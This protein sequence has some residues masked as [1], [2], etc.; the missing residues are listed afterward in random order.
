MD[1]LIQ[2]LEEKNQEHRLGGGVK[3]IE[4]EHAKGKLTA[5]ERL[6]YLFDKDTFIEVGLLTDHTCRDFGL[7]KKH[8][9]GDGVVTGYGQVDGRTVFAFAQD[10]TVV[11]GSLG[12]MHS[13]KICTVM[14]LA[15][16]AGA[17]IV[18]I[19]D[20]AGARVQEGAGGLAGYGL[21]FKRN[22]DASGVVPQIS[23]IMGN[24]AGGAVY[25]PAMTDFV[26]MVKKTSYM[27]ITGPK[28][29]KSVTGEEVTMETLGGARIHTKISGNCD[30][31]TKDDTECLE[32]V[33]RLLSFLPSNSKSQAPRLTMWTPHYDQDIH[34][35]IPDDRKKFFDVR[36]VIERLVDKGDFMEIKALYAPNVVVGF[37]RIDGRSVGIV[38]NQS[39]HLGGALDSNASDKAARFVRTCDAFNIPL[40]NLV[41]VPG[42]LP[43]VKHEY[44]GII[45]HGAKMIYAYSEAT[46]PKITII[47][48]KAYGG[49]YQAMCSKQLGADQVWA[50]PSA[51]VAVMGAEGAVDIVYAKEIAKADDPEAA[52]QA[53]IDE[54]RE[55]FANPYDVA[56]KLHVDAVILPGD[57]RRYLVQAL[58]A[59]EDK[60]EPKPWRK[61]GNV[62]L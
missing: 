44:S 22:V 48:R 33:K 15:V 40:V 62:P 35:I 50:W 57:T 27:F 4:K 14:D 55:K 46:V 34:K 43:G 20:S 39:R 56:K 21:I 51:E 31:A 6:D 12:D 11:G 41:D 28:V 18:G 19:N 47:L 7:E 10:A 5:R 49:A 9:P 23:V 16:K 52:R 42:Y 30:L 1:H 29:I 8:M 13:Q 25:S 60:Q 26:F 58:Q 45:R 32:Q 36:Q 3:R 2:E 54:Y 24:C 61:H 37:G 17:P 59:L 53:K 38:A